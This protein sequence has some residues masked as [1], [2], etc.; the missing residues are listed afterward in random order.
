MELSWEALREIQKDSTK[1]C[2]LDIQ[3]EIQRAE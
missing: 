3:M 1:G 2:H